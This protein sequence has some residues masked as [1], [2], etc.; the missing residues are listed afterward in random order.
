MLKDIP[1]EKVEGVAIAIVP[2][3]EDTGN[4]MWSVYILNLKNKPIDTVLISSSGYGSINGK[5]VKT[6][7][8]RFLFDTIRERTFVKIEPIDTKLFPIFNEFWVSFR[9]NGIL[10]DKKYVFVPESITEANFTKIP[11]LNCRGVMIR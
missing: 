4:K 5:K 11:L 6:S 10:Y 2:A 7:T 9:L 1:F 8:L 3:K